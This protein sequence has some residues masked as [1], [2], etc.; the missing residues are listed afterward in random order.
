MRARIRHG[1]L[2]LLRQDFD[3]SSVTRLARLANLAREEE[4]FWR[5]LEDD[6]FAALTAREPSGAIS[7]GIADLLSPFPLLTSD[8]GG[9]G[10]G[11]PSPPASTLAL[12]RRLVRRIYAALRGKRQNLIARHV[13]DVLDLAAKSHSGARIELPGVLSCNV[14]LMLFHFLRF[15]FRRGSTKRPNALSQTVN[16][17]TKFRCPSQP[18][19]FL[20]SSRKSGAGLI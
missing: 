20:L 9:A 11:T 6:R 17:N 8:A 15:L 16:L 19:S 18:K 4:T 10:H 7:V 2:P 1:L 14:I 3:P 12:T 5:A 13:Q